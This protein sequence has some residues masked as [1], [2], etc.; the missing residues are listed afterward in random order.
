MNKYIKY[1]A[2]ILCIVLITGCSGKEKNKKLTEN[3]SSEINL[4][5]SGARAVCYVDYDYTSSNGFVSGSKF[6]IYADNNN[7]VTRIVGRQIAESN[8]QSVLDTFEQSLEENY[9]VSSQY[10]GYK[11]EIK[12]NG[13][14]LVVDTDIDYTIIDMAA[15]AADNEEL[16]VYLNKE[17]KFTLEKVQAMYMAVGVECNTK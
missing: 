14:R 1:L 8:D 7:I 3:I 9:S 2:I 16:Q 4:D 6:V 12:Q 10:G 17:N 5:E 15:M 13:N 11:Y